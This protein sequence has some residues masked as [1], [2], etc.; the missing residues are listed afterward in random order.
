MII[1]WTS[2]SPKAYLIRAGHLFKHKIY[3][4]LNISWN[5]TK[6]PKEW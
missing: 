6:H 1:R 3:N 4:C 5:S 2:D